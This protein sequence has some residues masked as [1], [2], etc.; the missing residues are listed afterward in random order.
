MD[1]P[2]GAEPEG[3][4]DFA[5]KNAIPIYDVAHVGYPSRM[6][7][8]TARRKQTGET[9][10]PGPDGPRSDRARTCWRAIA[11]AD[12]PAGQLP[13]SSTAAMIVRT[14]APVPPFGV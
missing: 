11:A 9:G 14:A 5:R 8:W 3:A 10:P 6:R 2:A 7:E 4:R 12:A 13:S 1:T